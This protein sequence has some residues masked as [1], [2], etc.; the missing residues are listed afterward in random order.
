MTIAQLYV[1]MRMHLMFSFHI[2]WFTKLVVIVFSKSVVHNQ[3]GSNF[4]FFTYV[5]VDYLV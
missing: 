2:C 3:I 5:L 4:L 1:K